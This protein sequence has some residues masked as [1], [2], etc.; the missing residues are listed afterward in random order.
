MTRVEEVD[1]VLSLKVLVKDGDDTGF[2][3]LSRLMTAG[4]KAELLAA[5]FGFDA[6]ITRV[7]APGR[8]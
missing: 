8:I 6:K 2:D 5:G 1:V 3:L 4:V 7:A